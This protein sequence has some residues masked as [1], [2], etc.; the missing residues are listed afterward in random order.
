MPGYMLRHHIQSLQETIEHYVYYAEI[1]RRRARSEKPPTREATLVDSANYGECVDRLR[2]AITCLLDSDD[3][4]AKSK[5]N[6]VLSYNDP[7]P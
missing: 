2:C 3:A 1:L 6:C 7:E 5:P 4:I